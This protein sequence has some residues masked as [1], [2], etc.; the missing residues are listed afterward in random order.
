MMVR[1]QD[2][3]ELIFAGCCATSGLRYA[4]AF[5]WVLPKRRLSGS[6]GGSP[7]TSCVASAI[8]FVLSVGRLFGLCSGSGDGFQTGSRRFGWR[9][10]PKLSC[11]HWWDFMCPQ[12]QKV[13]FVS[14]TLWALPDGGLVSA[15]GVWLVMLL[16]KCQSSLVVF[17]CMWKRFVVRVSFPCFP[18]VAQG[19]GAGRAVGA[20][21]RTVVTFVV[22]VCRRLGMFG[23]ANLRRLS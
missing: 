3:S 21:P 13:G 19:G 10:P 23:F 16:W 14:R 8:C 5:W 11:L 1:S 18:L 22:K 4:V 17:P 15:M 7:R 20:L 12:D 2:C 6:G 9:F